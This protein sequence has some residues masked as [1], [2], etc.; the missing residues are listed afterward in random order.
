MIRLGICDHDEKILNLLCKMIVEQ[1]GE[2]LQIQTW[3]SPE[4]QL[5]G[6]EEGHIPLDIVLIDIAARR[7]SGIELAKKLQQ[8]SKRIK[9]VFITDFVEFAADIFEIE[10]VYL[11]KKPVSVLKL[12]EVIDR[13]IEKVRSEETQVIT[14][15]SKGAVFQINSTSISYVE[16]KERKLLVHRD[17]GDLITV[18]MKMD[19]LEEKLR[20]MQIFLRCHHSYLIN[21]K[22]IQTFTTQEIELLD[23]TKIPVSR[24]KSKTAKENFLAYLGE[25]I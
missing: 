24:P 12:V 4:E 18:Y 11:L 6:C 15:Q 14:F 7:E 23:G 16:S 2:Q 20:P 3:K 10:S 13:A 21:M 22:C 1:Y 9:I 19:E 8:F 17:M 25:Q 5:F